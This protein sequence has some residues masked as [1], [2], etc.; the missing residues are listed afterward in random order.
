MRGPMA[1]RAPVRVWARIRFRKHETL[2]RPPETVALILM[3]PIWGSGGVRVGR[4]GA[5]MP[6]G[7]V[8]GA[9]CCRGTKVMIWSQPPRRAPVRSRASSTSGPKASSSIRTLGLGLKMLRVP[10]IRIWSGLTFADCQ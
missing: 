3:S 8:W 2:M 4:V 9:A 5:Q 1:A 10:G 7:K 6:R